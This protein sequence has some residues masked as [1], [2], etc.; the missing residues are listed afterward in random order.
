MSDYRNVDGRMIPFVM[1]RFL[2]GSPIGDMKFDKV[3]FNVPL[4]DTLFKMPK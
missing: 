1:T 3:E 4:D 2:N